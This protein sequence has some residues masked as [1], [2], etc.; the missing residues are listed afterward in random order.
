MISE[1]RQAHNANEMQRVLNKKKEALNE[2][3]EILKKEVGQTIHCLQNYAL[4]CLV[5]RSDQ[6]LNL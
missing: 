5:N 2:Y 3:F 6:L 1:R 4:E